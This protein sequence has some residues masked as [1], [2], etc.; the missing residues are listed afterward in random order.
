MYNKTI[1]KYNIITEI[2]T[3]KILTNED[4]SIKISFPYIDEINISTNQSV[5]ITQK[6]SEDDKNIVNLFINDTIISTNNKRFDNGTIIITGNCT[7]ET[8]FF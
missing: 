3:I 7:V 1:V 2:P 6:I 4:I 8:L 5:Y